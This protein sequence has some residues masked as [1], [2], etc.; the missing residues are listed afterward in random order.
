MIFIAASLYLPEHL[1]KI[2]QR[3]FYYWSGAPPSSAAATVG[4]NTEHVKAAAAQSI[5][6][7]KST[8]LKA[9]AAVTEAAKE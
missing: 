2:T 1:L 6:Q 3:A 7:V 8:I 5:A 4:S 9:A